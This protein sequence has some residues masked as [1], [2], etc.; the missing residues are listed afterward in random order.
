MANAVTAL[1][2]NNSIAYELFY[3]PLLNDPKINELPFNIH[4]GKIGKELYY[5][6]IF[7]AVPSLKTACGWN[8]VEGS[9]IEKKALNPKELELSFKQ[10]YT[11]FVKSVFGDK[12]PDGYKKGELYPEI[13]NRI[14]EKQSNSL[15]N[16]VLLKTFLATTSN[17]TPFLSG[18]S[19]VY[20]A[21]LTGVA[22][23]DGTVDA[24]AI[25]DT[26]LLP[27][28]IEATMYRIY[29]AQSEQ[30]MSLADNTKVLIVTRSIASAYKRFLQTQ[31]G[32]TSILQTDYITKGIN[33]LTYN[34]I[35]FYVVDFVDRGL[36]LYDVTGSPASTLNPHRAILTVGSNHH[37]MIDGDGFEMV[38]PFYD[39]KDDIVYSPASAMV[40][41][42]YLFGDLNVIAG[43]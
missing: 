2:E 6:S 8:Y 21:L 1:P 31:T 35:P 12:L 27:A 40:D 5:D 10:C 26:D 30:L 39:R 24:G 18:A 32:M 13:I 23:G 25:T 9:P 11:D 42:V 20:E 41:Y 19:G 7:T 38:D 22:D 29:N 15:N 43:F 36:K 3:A 16:G 33:T 14:V 17:T 4:F 37:I 34:D 28:N